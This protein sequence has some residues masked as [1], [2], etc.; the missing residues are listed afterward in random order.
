LRYVLGLDP[1]G[2]E[3]HKAYEGIVRQVLRSGTKISLRIRSYRPAKRE[4]LREQSLLVREEQVLDSIPERVKAL[5]E[6]LAVFRQEL[7]IDRAFLS[8]KALEE[9]PSRELIAG[10]DQV[11]ERLN[12]DMAQVARQLAKA[13]KR[14]DEGIDKIRSGWGARKHKVEAAYNKILRELQKSAVDGEEFMRLRREIER[15]RP[16]RERLPIL[17]RLK[18]ESVERRRV[19]LAEWEEV[20]AEE[21]RLMHRAAKVVN[22]K[23]SDHVH[24]EVTVAGNREPL[25]SLLKEKI[26]GRLAEAIEKMVRTLASNSNGT[27]YTPILLRKKCQLS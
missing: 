24:V 12:H 9:L 22:T 5:R 25:V 13:L 15:L 18:K 20:K 23:L 17:A 4:Y 1:I 2:E 8:P 14:A 3:A 11:L 16:L 19:L 21:F 6:C 10:A 26:G 7:P 27:M